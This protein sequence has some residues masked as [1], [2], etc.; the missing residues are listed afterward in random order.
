MALQVHLRY[1]QAGRL[2][3]TG[4]WPASLWRSDQRAI[5]ACP[6]RVLNGIVL[7][8]S[9]FFQELKASSPFFLM[10]GPN[11]YRSDHSFGFARYSSCEHLAKE[12]EL[13]GNRSCVVGQV[14]ESEPHCMKMARQIKS[15]ADALELKL[16]F[17]ASFDKANRTSATSFRGPGLE[18]GL[19][20][21]NSSMTY[22]AKCSCCL[23]YAY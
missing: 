1:Q 16:I 14:I 9:A 21:V 18:E 7:Q 23:A 8:E 19:R 15:V 11:V 17:K 5:S 4:V 20:W 13:G 2:S 3:S 6:P 22:H 12:F 10:A